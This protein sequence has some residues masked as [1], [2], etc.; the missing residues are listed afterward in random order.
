MSAV[1]RLSYVVF[2]LVVVLTACEK[3][4]I[5]TGTDD[6]NISASV[7]TINEFIFENMDLY[8]FWNEE[9][10]ELDYMLQPDSWEYFDTL[11]YKPTDHWS[12]ITDDYESL[13]NSY[14][15]V[16]QSMGHSFALYKYSGSDNVYGIIQFVYPNSPAAEV[17][18]KRG[19][20]FTAIDDVNLDIENYNLLLNRPSYTLTVAEL[21]GTVITP[22][23]NVTLSERE[24]EENPIL[25]SRVIIVDETKIGYLNYKNFITNYN[26]QLI[27]SMAL[28]KE[29]GISEMILDLRYNNGGSIPAMEH[30][31]NI[32][33][34]L[35]QIT[36][37]DVMIVEEYNSNLTK[38]YNQIG[39]SNVTTF[40]DIGLNLGLTRIYIIVGSTTASAS[41]ALIIALEPYM[42]VITIG[43][44][45]H[46]KY[47]GA[48]VIPDPKKE[49]NWAIQPIVFKYSN[50]VGFTD[51]KDGLP[52]TI[53]GEDDLLSPLGNISEE[54]LAIAL[55]QITGNRAIFDKHAS[56]KEK[57]I[58]LE[59]FDRN[60]RRKNIPLLKED[61]VLVK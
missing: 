6:P 60:Q 40:S 37:Q 55:E 15:G 29:A 34:P 21:Q 61:F 48:W 30:L 31:A 20:F 9:M 7:L 28:L 46:G 43:E 41:E 45:T 18:L 32:L 59:S 33:V 39:I 44:Q 10:P 12:F 11:L 58:P 1:K 23:K 14:Q 24:I 54:L 51:F 53:E 19:D 13:N 22:I 36:N 42:E 2:F 56:I 3:D 26:D 17:G 52:P 57:L 4:P 38:Y 25:E 35:P 16:A 5:P 27:D 47:A 8:Y 49:H 50:S